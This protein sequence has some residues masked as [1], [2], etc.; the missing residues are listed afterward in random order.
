MAEIKELFSRYIAVIDKRCYYFTYRK[1][2]EKQYNIKYPIR[3]R[4]IYGERK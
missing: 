1:I 4:K 2:T 3:W